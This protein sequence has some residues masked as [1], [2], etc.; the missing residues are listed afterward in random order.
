[1]LTGRDA[2]KVARP[3]PRDRVSDSA[4]SPRP[5]TSV[6]VSHER[7]GHHCG[8]EEYGHAQQDRID[9]VTQIVD[10]DGALTTHGVDCRGQVA[11]HVRDGLAAFGGRPLQRGQPL[12]FEAAQHFAAFRRK[13]TDA[14]TRAWPEERRR[15]NRRSLASAAR[16][17]ARRDVIRGVEADSDLFEPVR[18]VVLPAPA[19]SQP[20]EEI[21]AA[22]V[23]REYDRGSATVLSGNPYSATRDQT[24]GTGEAPRTT[25]SR[26]AL[27]GPDARDFG[28]SPSDRRGEAF[29]EPRRRKKTG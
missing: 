14:R 1:M 20:L 16:V 27:P 17:D 25:Q 12:R 9:D 10:A 23:E 19:S 15:S 18:P 26:P 3:G 22:H 6:G 21:H 28:A 13:R 5:D 24:R 29:P 11:A 2:R 4:P 8:D 7:R